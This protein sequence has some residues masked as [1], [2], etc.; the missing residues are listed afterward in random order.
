MQVFKPYSAIHSSLHLIRKLDIKASSKRNPC[1][2]N[3]LAELTS[4]ELRRAVKIKER[5]EALER[6]LRDLVAARASLGESA[7]VGRPKR[8]MSAATRRRI[9]KTQRLRWA[10]EKHG[11]ASKMKARRRMP[12][13]VR[14]KISAAQHRR[15]AA[16]KASKV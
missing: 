5:I 16:V 15:W 3:F 4:V 6:E 1:M 10:R 13:A 12:A 2:D 11:G 9:G 14:A 8:T 7:N